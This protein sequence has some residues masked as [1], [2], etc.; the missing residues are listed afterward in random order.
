MAALCF[1]NGAL[2][3]IEATSSSNLNWDHALSFCGEEGT[4]EIRGDKPLRIELT[5]Y[6]LEREEKN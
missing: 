5:G 6:L 4:L 3:T 1:R 2:G